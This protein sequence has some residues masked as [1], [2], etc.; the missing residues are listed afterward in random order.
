MKM[1]SDFMLMPNS[2]RFDASKE[3][4]HMSHLSVQQ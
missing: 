3:E 2:S 1:Y 4:E